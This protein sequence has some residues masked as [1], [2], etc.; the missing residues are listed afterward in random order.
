M[1]ERSN[2]IEFDFFEEPAT[3]EAPAVSTTRRR[4]PRPP[5]RPPT[6]VTPLLR[7]AGLIAF[8]ILVVVLLVLWAQSC[9][10][11]SKQERYES[12]LG[13]VRQVG[14][15]SEGVGRQ[16]T[17]LLTRRGVKQAEV[18]RELNGLVQTQEQTI[19]RAREIDPPGRLR[20]QHGNMVDSLELR[21]DGLQLLSQGFARAAGSTRIAASAELL[22]QQ[23]QRLLAS[24]VVWDDL[25]R[26]PT[27][28]T[29]REQGLVGIT[30]PD[31]TFLVDRN[32]A[33]ARGIQPILQRIRGAATGGIPPGTH[34]NGIV[35]VRALPSGEVLDEDGENTVT[36]TSDLSFE[37]TIENSGDSQE[38]QVPV[39][40]T[41]QQT[42]EAIR[43]TQTLPVID[44]GRRE[45]VVFR[46]LGAVQIGQRTTLTVVVEKV[47][48][49]KNLANN[50]AEYEVT[51]LFTP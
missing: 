35:S 45:T 22:A 23:A 30:V 38:V 13:D 27:L 17:G 11:E 3:E 41:L 9:R 21:A 39:R 14:R 36:A 15:S 10:A 51:F 26:Q 32:L 46:N 47:P 48:G 5:V 49:E 24:D 4:G 43:R 12:Y 25:F 50:S 40:L 20:E 6:G 29:L 2:D 18:V 37:V 42:P 33:T 8:A 34:G 31:S 1:T 7:L 28:Q 16:L 44:A 19:T